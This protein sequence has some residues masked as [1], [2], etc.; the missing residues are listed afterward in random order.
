MCQSGSKATML[1]H[2]L[3]QHLT[4]SFLDFKEKKLFIDC[5]VNYEDQQYQCHRLVL[6]HFSS[7]FKNRFLSSNG[8]G[9]TTI[10]ITKDMNPQGQL[11]SVFD[12]FYD[13][14]LH[15]N[16]DNVI[17]LISISNLYGIP[18][19]KLIALDYYKAILS[20]KNVL[21]LSKKCVE[22]DVMEITDLL[23]PIISK[24]INSFNSE[25]L[26]QSLNAVILARVL[27]SEDLVQMTDDDKLSMIDEFH[28]ISPI[29]DPA[30]MALLS[31]VCNWASPESYKFLSKHKCL[32]MPPRDVRSLYRKLMKSRRSTSLEFSRRAQVI[33]SDVSCWHPLTWIQSVINGDEF[34][35][36]LTLDAVSFFPSMGRRLH[37]FDPL[38]Y[39][40]FVC[41]SS[42]TTIARN[43]LAH[44]LVSDPARYFISEVED[45][46]SPYYEVGFGPRTAFCPQRIHIRCTDSS[47][48]QRKVAKFHSLRA[49]DISD[50]D[51]ASLCPAPP[52]LRVE[53]RAPNGAY[54]TLYEGAYRTCIEP[55]GALRLSAVRFSAPARVLRVFSVALVGEFLCE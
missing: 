36:S 45:G 40:I 7:Y 38:P 26:L 50:S 6:S 39:G 55:R 3:Y 5:Y 54:E 46:A 21:Q 29:T 31:T 41:S 1:H 9:I 19:L 2:S 33:T 27:K 23:I 15:I 18:K 4:C 52:A 10:E 24:N 49:D 30:H 17:A 48:V 8:N 20:I 44:P 51:A 16:S 32:W 35:G 43:C 53:A 28:S 25:E 22:Y 42:R 34:H 37:N 12:F 14:Q 11:F 13:S 47:V